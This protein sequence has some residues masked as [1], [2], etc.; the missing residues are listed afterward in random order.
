MSILEQ[1]H[2]SQAFELLLDTK[3][4]LLHH[5]DRDT[6]SELRT[7]LI[8]FILSTD[9]TT[10]QTQLSVLRQVRLQYTECFQHC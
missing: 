1:A 3:T 10:H 2:C 8:T 6:V 7:L 5:F 4:G 9:P